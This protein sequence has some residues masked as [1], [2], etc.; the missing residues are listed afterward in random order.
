MCAY[1]T[2]PRN[3]VDRIDSQI[4]AIHLVEDGELER[5]V[6]IALFLISAYMDV[7]MIPAA[8]AEFM[9]ERGVRVK[10]ENDRLIDREERIEVRAGKTVL[11][12]IPFSNVA[13]AMLTYV[14]YKGGS[15][16]VA[17]MLYKPR[18]PDTWWPH[19][20]RDREYDL[21]ILDQ[22]DV[23]MT[24]IL[25]EVLEGMERNLERKTG[26]VRDPGI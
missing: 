23:P 26:R 3:A 22:F 2:E 4:K 20:I 16:G 9:D 24:A 14:A 17:I 15:Q 19:G 21:V 12:Q 7:V 11:G 1:G 5:G 18:D 8:V 13:S 25:R 6:D 10:I